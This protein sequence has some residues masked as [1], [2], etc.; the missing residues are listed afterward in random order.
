MWDVCH[1][2]MFNMLVGAA[3]VFADVVIISNSAKGSIRGSWYDGI[4]PYNKNQNH[5]QIFTYDFFLD[6]GSNNILDDFGVSF[7]W[8]EI[9]HQ[10]KLTNFS[11]EWG[12]RRKKSTIFAKDKQFNC[13]ICWKRFYQIKMWLYLS[14]LKVVNVHNFQCF[15]LQ[16]VI[17]ELVSSQIRWL[18]AMVS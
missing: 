5:D 2:V 12:K 17:N 15:A 6:L 10:K 9:S 7:F 4:Y 13:G 11:K 3:K 18:Q 14:E 16:C 8:R 1:F